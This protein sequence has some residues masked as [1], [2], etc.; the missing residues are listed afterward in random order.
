MQRRVIWNINTDVSEESATY[1]WNIQSHWNEGIKCC[2]SKYI[3]LQKFHNFMGIFRNPFLYDKYGSWKKYAQ[4]E[5]F[6]LLVVL[7][8]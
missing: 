6:A 4:V 8:F 7:F 2:I 3:L 5:L 1:I